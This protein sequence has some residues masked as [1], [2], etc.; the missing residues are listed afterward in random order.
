MKKFKG[1]KE[2]VIT[3][4]KKYDADCI[5]G[6]NCL[7]NEQAGSRFLSMIRHKKRIGYTV[8]LA[9][10]F[11][12]LV[13]GCNTLSSTPN[14][15]NGQEKADR[16]VNPSDQ[17]LGL[18][19]VLYYTDPDGNEKEFLLQEG[20][21]SEESVYGW[22]THA[23][24][25]QVYL[26]LIDMYG[27]SLDSAENLICSGGLQIYTCLDPLVQ[28]A[29]N[30]AYQDQGKLNSA[31]DS[32]ELLQSAIVVVDNETGQVA[33]LSGGIG[34]SEDG[35]NFAGD[36]DKGSTNN[37]AVDVQ[38]QPGPVLTPLSVY[39]PAIDMGFINPDSR[40]QDRPYQ[41]EW[42]T[43]PYGSYRGEMTIREAL[44]I[45]SNG[46]AVAVLDKYV[47][48]EISARF[49][50]NVFGIDVVMALTR[51][52]KVYTDVA[53]ENLALGALTF[54]VTPYEMAAAFSVFPRNGVYI[55]PT[56]YTRVLDHEGNELLNRAPE[57][58]VVLKEK[59][60]SYMSEMLRQAISTETRITTDFAG[61]EVAGISGDSATQ[62]D[63]WF[64][65][66]TPYYTA[67]VWSGYDAQDQIVASFSNDLSAKIWKQV[68][69][70]VHEGLPLKDFANHD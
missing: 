35:M 36:P 11:A 38:R 61:Q 64:V 63:V 53:L 67:A 49:L 43:N 1:K 62:Q 17:Y 13:T 22:Y 50:Q 32:G 16:G 29:V 47:T 59:T 23:V 27:I 4:R 2:L 51:G 60:A 66:Y 40:E 19:S 46:V 15:T 57:P 69:E 33:A 26:D 41:G 48:P 6:A 68:M 31:P 7:A 37:R 58:K 30:A 45:S 65:G 56:L 9:L 25:G 70:R 54:G 14:G 55:E 10:L 12:L 8:V 21:G 44:S 24:L 34:A 18:P 5:S 42:P 39:A 28:D 52:D 3:M 20:G